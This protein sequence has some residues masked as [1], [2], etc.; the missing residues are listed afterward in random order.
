MV[1]KDYSALIIHDNQ[2]SLFNTDGEILNLPLQTLIAELEQTTELLIIHKSYTY[3]KLKSP[4][5]I[6]TDRW[7]DLLE[8]A[9]FVFPVQSFGYTVTNFANALKIPMPLNP[10]ADFL[11]IICDY[12]ILKFK[13]EYN[14]GNKDLIAARLAALYHAQ[15]LWAPILLS[16][17]DISLP[18]PA[19]QLQ[20]SDALRIWQRL[21]KWQE[22]SPRPQPSQFPVKRQE[23]FNRLAEIL[24]PSAEDRAGQIDFTDVARYAFEPCVE[25][26]KPNI[27]LA[28]AGTGTGKTSAYIAPASLWAEHNK[29]T[30]WINT[31][32]RHLQRQIE[33]EF[34]HLY[35]DPATRKKKIVVRKG[36]ENYLCLLNLDEYITLHFNKNDGNGDNI[37]IILLCNWAEQSNDGDLF[38]G[39]LP[40]WFHDLF[41]N[42][43]LS[44]LAER[45]GECIHASCPHYQT[46]FVEHSIRR[47][48]NAEI[49]IANHALVINHFAWSLDNASPEWESNLPSR[50]IFD[51]AH[52]ISDAADS[53]FSTAFSATETSEL[54]RWLLGNEGNNTRSKGLKKRIHDVIIGNKALEKDLEEIIDSAFILPPLNWSSHLASFHDNKDENLTNLSERFFYLIYQQIQARSSRNQIINQSYAE[55]RQYEC[56]LYPLLPELVALVPNLIQ[57]FQKLLNC[58][59]KF[60]RNIETKL[61]NEKDSLD[62]MSLERLETTHAT[63]TRKAVTPLT[64]WLD[65]LTSL[66]KTEHSNSQPKTHVSFLKSEHKNKNITDVGLFHHWLDPTIPLMKMLAPSIQGMLFT[67]ATLRDE[68]NNDT[69]ASWQAAEQRVGTEHLPVQPLRAALSCPFNYDKQA[70][71]FVV[72]DINI[73]SINEVAHAY[74]HL[75]KASK[76]GALGL[77]TAIHRLRAI[78]H[79]INESLEKDNISLFAQHIDPLSNNSLVELFKNDMR[80]CLLGTDA[81]RD[82]INIPGNSL[83]LVVFERIP[84]PRPDILYRER[85][86]YF[87]KDKPNL[88][89]EQIVRLRLRQAFGRLIRTQSDKGIFII[90]DRRTP[91]RVL[92]AFPKNVPIRRQS[93]QEVIN[94]TT[95][96]YEK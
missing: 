46:C 5:T 91:T 73:H 27:V 64:L 89:D 95:L 77:F 35:P 20:A 45:R 55:T 78:Y 38:G 52:H 92:S 65:L 34:H 6:H 15:W 75:F 14:H 94:Q 11:I 93:L 69:E 84:W 74:L 67:S 88:Y 59:L 13:E 33:H 47:A 30:V 23:T 71:V 61:N 60:T 63:L 56:D 41:D 18:L 53:A 22:L 72:N 9:A 80:S 44:I 16:A 10:E 87:Y 7:L 48:Q 76:G 58:L 28:E 42:R 29:G 85:R 21:P 81:M 4:K 25:Q 3:R 39:D 24:G 31:Y 32:T 12:L 83:R 51:E 26:G 62:K 90:L 43:I 1:L 54:R 57:S 17:L 49:V 50:L 86:K 37:A 96:F 2:F 66:N 19:Q 36:R 70:R 8:L 40:N 68:S 82:G 79:Q